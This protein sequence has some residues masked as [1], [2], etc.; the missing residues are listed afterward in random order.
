MSPVFSTVGTGMKGARCFRTATGPAPGP[1]PPCGW[2]KVLCRLIWITSTPQS[3]G[4]VTPMMAFRLAPSQYTC[5]PLAWTMA[6]ISAMCSS[7]SPSVL[8]L[9]II[10]AATWSSITAATAAGST[11]PRGPDFT[12]TT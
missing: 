7:N 12:G 5:P 10:T 4:R 3:P 9:V 1:P 6:A 2:E 8:G 11:T